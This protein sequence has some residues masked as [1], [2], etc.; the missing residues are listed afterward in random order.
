MGQGQL[1]RPLPA[2]PKP[3]LLE[4]G[5]WLLR[6]R[7]RLRVVGSSMVPFLYP[8]DELLVDR[9]AYESSLPAVGDLVVAMHPGQPGLRIVKRV[10]AAAN[11][12][13]TLRGDN[14]A[15]STD[16]RSFGDIPAHMISGKVTS[17]FYRAP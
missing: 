8:G 12:T 10:V 14:S 13:C 5:L 17:L 9:Q 3:S 16:S 11:E 7:Y 15:A 2:V 1:N 4:F 6:R